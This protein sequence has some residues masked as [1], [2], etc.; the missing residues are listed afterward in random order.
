MKEVALKRKSE[1][2]T[3]MLDTRKKIDTLQ[4]FLKNAQKQIVDLTHAGAKAEAQYHIVCE[5]LELNP[6]E[7]FKKFSESQKEGV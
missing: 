4:G 2:E 5:L 7:E 1:L 3:E 6:T